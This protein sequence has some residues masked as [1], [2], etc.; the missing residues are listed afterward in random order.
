MPF[1]NKAKKYWIVP[2]E[3]LCPEDLPL[4]SILT[5]PNNTIDVLNRNTVELIDPSLIIKEREQVSKSLTEAISNGFGINFE[6][7]SALAAIIGGVPNVGTEW[8]RGS[9][10]SIEATRVRAQHFSPSDEYADRALR[11][12]KVSEYVG[13]SFFTAAVYMIVGVAIAST[14]TRKAGKSR[15]LGLKG[16]AGVGPP[17]TGVEVSADLSTNRE[18]KSSYQDA[19]EE[20]VVLA[21]RLRRFRYSKMRDKIT[22][23]KED[24]TDHARYGH[25]PDASGPEE[26]EDDEAGFVPVFSYF[27][28]DDFVASGSGLAGFTENAEDDDPDDSMED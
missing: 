1:K 16:G 4:G 7:S 12:Q 19:V 17:G 25:D 20:D 24:E 27:E 10:D 23:K 9:E 14:V 13:R 8:S 2:Q 21:Y 28:D 5:T 3:S 6:A 15:N 22:K 11:A 18:A 26:D